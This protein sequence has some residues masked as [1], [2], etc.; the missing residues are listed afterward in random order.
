MACLWVFW[1]RLLACL[2]VA[3]VWCGSEK[4]L[5]NQDA[6]AILQE[7][8]WQRQ[9][10]ERR[11][12]VALNALWRRKGR[13]W[14]VKQKGERK[15]RNCWGGREENEKERER[16]EEKKEM[17]WLRCFFEF[18][19][20][21]NERGFNSMLGTC[22][23]HC[24]SIYRLVILIYSFQ[25]SGFCPFY[26]MKKHCLACEAVE[27]GMSMKKCRQPNAF[28][29]ACDFPFLLLCCCALSSC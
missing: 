3:T 4:K 23:L 2:L 25:L 14:G 12:W 10:N 11:S 21:L 17:G 6:A 5:H 15:N 22:M 29:P 1:E 8:V 24:D 26:E 9:I 28:L 27:A 13:E 7:G 20:K 18:F 16:K 19:L